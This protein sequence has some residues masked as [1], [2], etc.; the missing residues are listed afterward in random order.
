MRDSFSNMSDHPQAAAQGSPQA[1]SSAF[2]AC[3]SRAAR[4]PNLCNSAAHLHCRRFPPWR[5]VY[6]DGP[7]P[8]RTSLI[9]WL[10]R[11]EHFRLFLTDARG[12]APDERAA[13]VCHEALEYAVNG[14]VNGVRRGAELGELIIELQDP[15][16]REDVLERVLGRLVRYLMLC[17][18]PPRV[19]VRRLCT[20]CVGFG[21]KDRVPRTAGLDG[22]FPG[23]DC[24]TCGGWGTVATL[25]PET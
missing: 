16:N 9:L 3:S 22:V 17:G 5:A 10:D 8:P 4:R 14:V 15:E 7:A 1:A 19:A 18:F 12:I 24:P 11:I 21:W 2:D 13:S 25:P 20:R 23:G 6:R